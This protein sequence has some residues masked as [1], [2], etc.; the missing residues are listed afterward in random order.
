[1]TP[2]DIVKQVEVDM[3]EGGMQYQPTYWK[4]KLLFRIQALVENER[5]RAKKEATLGNTQSFEMGSDIP[6]K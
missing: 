4:N 5:A 3:V 1:M 2:E 6:V